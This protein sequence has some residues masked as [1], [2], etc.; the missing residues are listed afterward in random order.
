MQ[1]PVFYIQPIRKNQI[2]VIGNVTMNATGTPVYLDVEGDPDRGFYYCIGLR[3]KAGGVMVQRSYWAD[4][5]TEERTIWADCLCTLG[6]IEAPRLVHYG[7][8][9]TTFLRQMKKRYPNPERTAL[10]DQLIA[11]A[12]NLLSTIYARVYFPTYSN[13]LKDVARHLGFRWSDPTAS[14]LVALA[15]RREWEQSQRPDLKQ[16]LAMYNAED[17]P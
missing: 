16:M 6:A 7:S 8:Y 3:F 10:L 15:W 13:G 9:E 17:L 1:G 11:S 5:P 4:S 14:G 12:V 2:H